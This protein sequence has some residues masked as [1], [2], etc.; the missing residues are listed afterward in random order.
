MNTNQ[1]RRALLAGAPVAAAAALAA[2]TTVNGLAAG[3]ATPSSVDPIFAAIER[4]RAA[5]TVYLATTAAADIDDPIPPPSRD[6]P[7]FEEANERRMAR[8]EHQAWWARWKEA[9]AAHTEAAQ[10]LW[11]AR[12]A[13]LQTQPTS[14]AGLRA[15]LD[16]IEGPFSSDEVGEA[17]WDEKEKEL[18]FPTLAAALRNIIER[19]RA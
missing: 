14:V 13:F 6:D 2:G 10:G 16:H 17:N 15:Y 3:L 1:S 18:A 19:G 7:D 8:P 4:E 11:A 5:H 9:D 12:E